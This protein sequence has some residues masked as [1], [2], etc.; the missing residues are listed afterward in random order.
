MAAKA[1]MAVAIGVVKCILMLSS[2]LCNRLWWRPI[3]VAEAGRTS[4]FVR[5]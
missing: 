3:K 1:M 4:P 2:V 5:Y